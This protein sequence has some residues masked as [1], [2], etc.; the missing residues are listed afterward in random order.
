MYPRVS[1]NFKKKLKIYAELIGSEL[2]ELWDK[3]PIG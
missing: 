1:D 3:K 2:L